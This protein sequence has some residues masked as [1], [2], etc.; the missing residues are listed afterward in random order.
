M[1][2]P[3]CVSE[4]LVFRIRKEGGCPPDTLLTDQTPGDPTCCSTDFDPNTS[5]LSTLMAMYVNRTRSFPD[6]DEL[7]IYKDW[8]VDHFGNPERIE[9]SPLCEATWLKYL[10]PRF[11]QVVIHLDYEAEGGIQ[12]HNTDFAVDLFYNC[13]W[14]V[15]NPIEV[16]A[17]I[18]LLKKSPMNTTRLE[19]AYTMGN[20]GVNYIL[21]IL[22]WFETVENRHVEIVF[23]HRRKGESSRLQNRLSGKGYSRRRSDANHVC[24]TKDHTIYIDTEPYLR[25]RDTTTLR[26]FAGRHFRN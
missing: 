2:Q 20:A 13:T 21:K 15:H 12:T 24:M 7:E 4:D 26:C 19:L 9:L 10:K 6:Y 25:D 16:G 18:E 22:E 14:I 23:F 8:Y 11:Y 3:P 5:N 17:S 1:A